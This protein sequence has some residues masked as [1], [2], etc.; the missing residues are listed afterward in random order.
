[1]SKIIFFLG[2]PGSGK[3]TQIKYLEQK[4]EFEVVRTGDLLRSRA[5]ED[6]F[7]GRKVKECL[8]KGGLIPTP[9]VFLLW[10]PRLLE[11]REKEVKG[12]IFD[13]NPRKLYEAKMLE[14]VFKM[15]E[16]DSV[17]AVYLK[18]SDNEAHKRLSKRKRSDDEKKDIISRL[19]W[20]NGEVMPVVESY[21][22][23]G[24]LIEVDGEQEI[25][26]VWEELSQKIAEKNI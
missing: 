11:F 20:F 1:M 25:E 15:F 22:Q 10:M 19:E 14:E 23:Q 2:K 6:D 4:T 17:F 7:V 13:G 8:L 12:I 3:G 18:I 9:I 26:E 5:E 21:L 24:R 16:W